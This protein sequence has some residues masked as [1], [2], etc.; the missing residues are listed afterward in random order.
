MLPI[1]GFKPKVVLEPLNFMT[2]GWVEFEKTTVA[3]TKPESG[4]ING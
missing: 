1:R 2:V 3:A 4:G